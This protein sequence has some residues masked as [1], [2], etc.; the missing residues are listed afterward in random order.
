MKPTF[1]SLFLL[2]FYS[3]FFRVFSS[4]TVTFFFFFRSK[5]GSESW[6]VIARFL[7][8]NNSIFF[9]FKLVTLVNEFFFVRWDCQSFLCG[10]QYWW[11][12]SISWSMAMVKYLSLSHEICFVCDVLWCFSLSLVCPNKGVLSPYLIF[13]FYF[14]CVLGGKKSYTPNTNAQAI[15]TQTIKIEKRQD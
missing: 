7:V 13:E 4:L 2:F 10:A 5:K 6:S 9:A 14:S 15:E 3:C 1:Y 12:W 8:T 11:L